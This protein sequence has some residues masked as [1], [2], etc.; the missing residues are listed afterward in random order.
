MSGLKALL[1]IVVEN[2]V[3]LWFSL[4][5]I[6][7]YWIPTWCGTSKK[8][9]GWRNKIFL[10]IH[11]FFPPVQVLYLLIDWSLSTSHT[12]QEGS[13][14]IGLS[15]VPGPPLIPLQLSFWGKLNGWIFYVQSGR[16]CVQH[17]RLSSLE[18]IGW[19]WQYAG[20]ILWTERKGCEGTNWYKATRLYHPKSQPKPVLSKLSNFVSL[21]DSDR[22]FPSCRKIRYVET[23]LMLL[24]FL[25]FSSEPV[26]DLALANLSFSDIPI[27]D[28]K[29]FL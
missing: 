18:T 15:H 21:R 20:V 19:W 5:S 24:S 28:R 13:S 9:S 8:F 2:V 29:Y 25:P 11:K 12:P 14:W 3:L 4:A 27:C 7:V 1:D 23:L 17:P 10:L 6:I 26:T 16:T 22:S